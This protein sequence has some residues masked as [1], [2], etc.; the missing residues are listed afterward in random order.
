MPTMVE[1]EPLAY[2]PEQTAA[3]LNI[4]P[5]TIYRM[6]ENG[7]LPHKRIIAKGTGLRGRIIIPADAL[8]KWLAKP[9]EPRQALMQKKASQIAKDAVRKLRSAR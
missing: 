4:S 5:S 6:V 3:L 2:S 1:T 8:K 9:D 7:T